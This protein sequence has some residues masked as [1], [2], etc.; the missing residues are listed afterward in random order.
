MMLPWLI[1]KSTFHIIVN[2]KNINPVEISADISAGIMSVRESYKKAIDS[3]FE[4]INACYKSGQNRLLGHSKCFLYMLIWIAISPL[5]VFVLLFLSFKIILSTCHSA[6]KK[7]KSTAGIAYPMPGHRSTVYILKSNKAKDELCCEWIVSH[8]HIHLCQFMYAQAQGVPYY[9]PIPTMP[10]DYFSLNGQVDNK[11]IRYYH[12]INELEA[13]LHELVLNNYRHHQQLPYSVNGFI[14]FCFIRQLNVFYAFNECERKTI[15]SV[16]K[17][18]AKN[19][20]LDFL[21]SCDDE[22][23]LLINTDLVLREPNIGAEWFAILRCINEQYRLS[24][25]FEVLPVA[26]YNLLTYYGAHELADKIGAQIS[27][28]NLYDRFYQGT[29]PH[30]YDINT[31][32]V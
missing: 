14:F 6:Y 9:K 20:A 11:T 32:T 4:G 21:R 15:I 26:Y 10:A 31:S 30:Q 7:H 22:P 25:I 19:E 23:A 2:F 18:T 5:L 1:I 17:A 13:R 29:V 12:Q 28:P 16:L 8:E 3:F 24:F 27:R